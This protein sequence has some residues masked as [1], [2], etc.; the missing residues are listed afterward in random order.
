MFECIGILLI[1]PLT[2]LQISCRD[3]FATKPRETVQKSD[4]SFFLRVGRGNSLLRSW[5]RIPS[6]IR[7]KNFV[8]NFVRDFCAHLLDVIGEDGCNFCL[9]C[10]APL[11]NPFCA[12][13]GEP[14]FSV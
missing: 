7:G 4:E 11:A 6:R 10:V 5:A 1:N 8:R 9:F 2:P 13:R 14:H 12:F 3:F